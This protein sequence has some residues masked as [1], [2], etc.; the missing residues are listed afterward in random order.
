MCEIWDEEANCG[1]VRRAS[2]KFEV[3]RQM[4][5]SCVI[6]THPGTTTSKDDT[7]Q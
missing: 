1:F 7:H 2:F 4:M 6:R 5:F 3:A